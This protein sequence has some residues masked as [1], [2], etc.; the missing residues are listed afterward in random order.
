MPHIAENIAY[1]C[2]G[3]NLSLGYNTE[4]GALESVRFEYLNLIAVY[5]L[6]ALAE[7]QSIGK[8]LHAFKNVRSTSRTITNPDCTALLYEE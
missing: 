6:H 4:E 3:M 5:M 1:F 7:S 8:L 2:E